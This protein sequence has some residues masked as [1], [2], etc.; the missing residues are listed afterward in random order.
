MSATASCT[1]VGPLC[2]VRAGEEVTLH[3]RFAMHPTFGPQFKT[4]SYGAP[5]ETAAAIRRYLSG[6]ALPYIGKAIAA[7]IVAAFGE[8][9]LEV[10]A[11]QPRRW[12][13]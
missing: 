11:S 8:E 4:E 13:P 3:G 9:S 10:I 6:G 5:A 7:R 12:P 1:A 2:E